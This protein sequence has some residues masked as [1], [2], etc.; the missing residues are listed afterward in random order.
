MANLVKIVDGQGR[1]FDSMSIAAKT[2]GIPSSTLRSAVAG[3]GTYKKG[4]VVLSVYHG[5][6]QEA[7]KASSLVTKREVAEYEEFKEYKKIKESS[8]QEFEK[9]DFSQ[10]GPPEGC[11]Y[12]VALL[13]DI[14]LGEDV[15]EDSTLGLNVY[16]PDI[17]TERVRTFFQR[18]VNAINEDG[19]SEVFIGCLGDLIDGFLRESAMQE[20]RLTPI[21]STL[22]V[23]SLLFS[24]LEYVC[25]N[26]S[27]EKLHFIGITGNHGRTTQRLQSNNVR[28]SYEY[29]IY[30]N[31]KGQCEAAGLPI[32]FCIPDSELAVV[33][34]PDGKRAIFCHGWQIKSQGTGTVCGIYPALNRLSMKW[35]RVFQQ[36][37]LFLGHFHSVISI[38]HV[39]VNG[40]IVGYN[41]FSMSNGF[42]F[43]RPA[44]LYLL[45][46]EGQGLVLTRTIYCD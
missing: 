22:K 28:V 38:P 37:Y 18:L 15:S 17:C 41:A 27:L 19:I 44:Q 30:Q 35:Q 40:S 3:Y 21:E 2:Y 45:Y 20:N 29:L 34:F 43:E 23:Q 5:D 1:V 31:V 11:R 39:A 9:F 26:T 46:G 14:H 13:S 4:D 33:T 16:D 32:D 12:A 36:D 25:N 24:G 7:V 8:S 42:S 10:D 6:S